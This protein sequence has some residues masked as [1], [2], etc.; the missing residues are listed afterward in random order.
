MGGPVA[1]W[2]VAATTL[3]SWRGKDHADSPTVTIAV[4]PY[5]AAGPRYR[6]HHGVSGA[7][8]DTVD[9]H[10]VNDTMTDLVRPCLQRVHP[11]DRVPGRDQRGRPRAAV[12]LGS[13]DHLRII[14]VVARLLP[15]QPIT[16]C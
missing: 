10:K 11:V 2:P 8:S 16:T 5:P 3:P 15:D 6:E 7:K 9:S 12:G 14:G 13:D 1:S 4:P